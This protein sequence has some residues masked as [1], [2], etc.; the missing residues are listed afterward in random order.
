M[1]DTALMF[2]CSEMNMYLL[3]LCNNTFPNCTLVHMRKPF[4]SLVFAC[5]NPVWMRLEGKSVHPTVAKTSCFNATFDISGRDAPFYSTAEAR[6]EGKAKSW[7]GEREDLAYKARTH[8]VCDQFHDCDVVGLC[9][10]SIRPRIDSIYSLAICKVVVVTSRRV[11]GFETHG[12]RCAFFSPRA[13]H[14]R[15]RPPW[16]LRVDG[17]RV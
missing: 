2:P 5:V 10:I 3:E 13:V 11:M 16:E 6:N 1:A 4:S 14:Q 12:D 8:M 15:L 9:H 7:G 17:Q